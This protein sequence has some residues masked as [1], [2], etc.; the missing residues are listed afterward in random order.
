MPKPEVYVIYTGDRKTRPEQI[1]LST[2][3]FGG[4]EV[5]L[6][7]NVKM[8]YDGKEGGYNKPVCSIHKSV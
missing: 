2:E 1:S 3:F 4:E 6:D 7:L 5:C 8:T